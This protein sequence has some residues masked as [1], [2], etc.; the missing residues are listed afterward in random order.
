MGSAMPIVE[1][2]GLILHVPIESK[3]PEVAD[4]IEK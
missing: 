4:H 1:F 2:R 3:I